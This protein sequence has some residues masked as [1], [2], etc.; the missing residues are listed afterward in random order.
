MPDAFIDRSVLHDSNL[1]RVQVN[2]PRQCQQIGIALDQFGLIAAVDEVAVATMPAIEMNRVGRRQGL[3]EFRVEL[4]VVLL[5]AVG[6]TGQKS[7]AIGIV[8]KS[9]SCSA[10]PLTGCRS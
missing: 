4:N 9:S 5:D 7:F 3:H 8:P 6:Q 2:L 10:T 1:H